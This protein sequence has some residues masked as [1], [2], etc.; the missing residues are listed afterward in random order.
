MC[1]IN[2][3]VSTNSTRVTKNEI[4]AVNQ[5]LNHRGPDGEGIY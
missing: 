3:I 1:G 5:A 2:G 4:N